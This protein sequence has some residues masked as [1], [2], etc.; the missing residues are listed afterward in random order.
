MKK[1]LSI[2]V[3]LPVLAFASVDMTRV[4]A[5]L[6]IHEPQ[7]DLSAVE[8]RDDVLKKKMV[9]LLFDADRLNH[10]LSKAYATDA[11]FEAY[12]DVFGGRY[13]LI[14][15]NHDKTPELVFEGFVA[16]SDDREH[17]EIYSYAKGA[18]KKIYDELGHILAYKI[19]PNTQEILLFHHQYPCCLNASHNLN[20]LRF[21][22]GE[23]Q[24]VKRY[25]LGRNAGD[26]R[27]KLFPD[28]V[29]FTGKYR[30]TTK[31]VELRWSGSVIEKDAWVRRASENIIARYEKGS[32]YTVLGEEN[33][34][35][36]VLMHADPVQEQSKVVNTANLKEM[37]VYGW[38]R[39]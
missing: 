30:Q 9:L 5:S 8:T 27:G 26:M 22:N 35:Y 32:V 7:T 36:F 24:S 3:F 11:S 33:G 25:F 31:S 28:K 19:Q 29:T 38:I 10:E 20:R 4:D 18:L 37:A 21:V 6:F 2:V 13:R 17:V 1:I 39:K 12:Y 15:L 23:L 14:D 16:A 34:W